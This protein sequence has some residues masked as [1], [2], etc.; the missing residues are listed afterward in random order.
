MTFEEAY[1]RYKDKIQTMLFF[2]C[3][4]SEDAEDLAQ[5][6]WLKVYKGLDSFNGE[7]ALYTWIYSIARNELYTHTG[8]HKKAYRKQQLVEDS[9]DDLE[10]LLE[11]ASVEAEFEAIE[12]KDE[13]E[14]RI[15]ELPPEFKDC[16]ILR[17][18]AGYSYDEIAEITETPVNTVRSRLHRARERVLGSGEGTTH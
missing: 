6:V 11:S 18:F 2:G 12:L 16:L 8:I 13:I 1:E 15:N 10:P 7:S 17:E 9:V 14:R 4:S 3:G 5:T